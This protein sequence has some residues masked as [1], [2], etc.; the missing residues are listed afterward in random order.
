MQMKIL[1]VDVGTTT[2]KCGVVNLD[3]LSFDSYFSERTELLT[4][5]PGYVEEDPEKLWEAVLNVS[6]RCIER[7]DLRISSVVFTAHMGGVVPVNDKGEPLDNIIVWLDQRATGFPEELWHGWPRIWGY[8]LS[9]YL[10]SVRIAGGVPARIGKDVLSKLCWIK[11]E[12]PEVYSRTRKFLDVR[13]YLVARATGVMLT[14]Q[15]EASITWLADTRNGRALWSS[16]LAGKYR[17][18]ASKLCEIRDTVEVAGHLKPEV[19]RELGIQAVPVFVGAGDM[20][21]AALGSGA[22][23][24]NQV[25]VYVGTSDWVG[26]HISQRKRDFAHHIGSLLSAIPARYLLIG[27]QEMAGGALDWAMSLLGVQS[28]KEV[29]E[30]L[31]G[32]RALSRTVFTPWLSGERSPVDDPHVRGGFFNL[33]YTATRED[34]LSAVVTGVAL[35]IKWVYSYIRKITG[36]QEWVSVVGGGALIDGWCQRITDALGVTIKVPEHPERTGLR[37]S[38]IIAAAGAGLYTF[39][40]ATTRIRIEREFRPNRV[41]F[42]RLEKT[43]RAYMAIYRNLAEIY[44]GLNVHA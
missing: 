14:S 39:R 40:D 13:G 26:A 42:L 44:R 28:Y 8:S 11:R 17:L 35:N 33:D 30:S 29:E 25:H 20:T 7:A 16:A 4:P 27:V 21:S 37:G 23:S 6:R 31:S 19:A 12:R 15:D 36:S 10:E 18:D 43:F 1:A 38:A 22:L 3:D 5:K 41:D 24:E 34:L 9:R 32:A 2:L